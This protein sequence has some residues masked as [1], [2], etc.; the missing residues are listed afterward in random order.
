[1]NDELLT[2]PIVREFLTTGSVNITTTKWFVC[3]NDTGKFEFVASTDFDPA[4]AFYT[5]YNTASVDHTRLIYVKNPNYTAGSAYAIKGTYF[6]DLIT[7]HRNLVPVAVITAP[8]ILSG[9][10]YIVD[11]PNVVFEDARRFIS[12]GYSGLASPFTFG[13]NASFRTFEAL[14]TW[15]KELNKYKAGTI[16]IVNKIGDTVLVK[17]SMDVSGKTFNFGKKIKFV[18]D[19]GRLVISTAAS[20]TNIHLENLRLDTTIAAAITFN[21]VQ[22]NMTACYFSATTSLPISIAT[23]SSARFT[24]NVFTGIT[25]T[26]ISNLSALNAIVLGNVYKTGSTLISATYLPATFALYNSG[27]GA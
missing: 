23:T 13:T 25:G 15:L 8:I 24:N 6:S 10:A 27:D 19:G 5:Y 7:N 14:N 21:G 17:D 16:N 1:V 11:E 2:I 12:N 4:G 18:G 9:T 20:M 3:V 22:N 26:Y